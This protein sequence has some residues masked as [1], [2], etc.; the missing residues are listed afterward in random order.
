VDNMDNSNYEIID[1]TR[2]EAY[3]AMAM[4]EAK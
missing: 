2:H 1:I 3:M 4:D